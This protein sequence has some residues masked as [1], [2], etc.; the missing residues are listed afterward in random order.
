[1]GQFLA[2]R[3]S[4]LAAAGALVVVLGSSGAIDASTQPQAPSTAFGPEDA[5]LTLTVFSDFACEPCAHFAV[6]LQ[7]VIE[8]RP[9]TVR[10]VFRHLPAED[11]RGREAHVASLAAAEQGR[12]AEFHNLA[13]ANQDRLTREDAVSM[14]EQL[15]L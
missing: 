6:V 4:G 10:V 12:F 14:A 2:R 7:G 1:M 11:S 5:P 9:D 13:F 3:I 15:G 8:A